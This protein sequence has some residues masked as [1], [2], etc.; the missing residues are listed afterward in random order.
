MDIYPIKTEADYDTALAEI[1]R[2]WGAV[3]GSPDGDRLDILLA[4]VESY[5][6]RHYPILPPGPIEAIKF[7]ME[8]MSLTR[9]DLEPLIGSRG[10]GHQPAASAVAGHDPQTP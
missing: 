7:R 9:R 6:A 3:A 4:L 5:E 10:R 8:Q 2:L 1:E